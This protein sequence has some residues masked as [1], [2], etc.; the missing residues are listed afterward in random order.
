MLL[1][2]GC[3]TPELYANELVNFIIQYTE[4]IGLMS[5]TCVCILVLYPPVYVYVLIALVFIHLAWALSA[6]RKCKKHLIESGDGPKHTFPPDVPFLIQL[7]GSLLFADPNDDDNICS[8]TVYFRRS[9][10]GRSCTS[11]TAAACWT[12]VL[13][14]AL[15][16]VLWG[17]YAT[18]G[19]LHIILFVYWLIYIY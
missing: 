1:S 6:Q 7:L 4:T 16:C 2:S 13:M 18:G 15:V 8:V 12:V 3:S 5:N 17:Y 14:W 19:R 11:L 9:E 10:G